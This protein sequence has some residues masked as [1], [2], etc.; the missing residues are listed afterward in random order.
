MAEDKM[1]VKDRKS[2]A[3]DYLDDDTPFDINLLSHNFFQN[4]HHI[5]S[6]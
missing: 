3:Q 6:L 5:N 1:Q 2:T 4:A